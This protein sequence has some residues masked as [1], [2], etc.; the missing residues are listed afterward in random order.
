MSLRRPR[1][2]E[3]A[4]DNTPILQL[5]DDRRAPPTWRR[6]RVARSLTR[7]WKVVVGV[8]IL[9]LIE[10]VVHVRSFRIQRPAT[11]LDPPFH[12]GC[13]T[14]IL[15]TTER[16]NAAMVMLARNTDVDGAIDSIQSV[17][18]QFNQHFGYPWVFLNDKD[19]SP[20][21]VSRVGKVVKETGGGEAYFETI[22]TYMWGYPPWI[23]QGKARQ[24]MESM[25][26]RRIAYADIEITCALTYDPFVEM[27][28]NDKRYGYTVA[29]WEL[30]KT[31]PTLFQKLSD[32]K[33][34]RNMP[35]TS[36]WTAMMAPAWLP[37]PFRKI[38]RLLRNRDGNGD[39]WNMCHFWSNFE[40]ADMTFFRS[41][42]YREFFQFLDEDGGF[43]YERWGDAPVHSLAAGLLLRPDQVHHFS[44]L[45]YVH[46]PFQ[47]CT[48]APHEDAFKRGELVPDFDANDVRKAT[49]KEIGCNCFC[50]PNI[51]QVAPECFNRIKSTVM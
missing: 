40:I 36:L 30:G 33:N 31:V 28:R 39:M 12:V 9:C 8:L 34:K 23:D 19:W 2:S 32:W 7:H 10:S 13:Q 49:E 37:W 48:F 25:Q 14:P 24:E 16:A 22:P 50:D 27:E 35:S 46:K 15:N 1:T 29:L 17:Q 41:Q 6:R 21:F 42:E 43:Y 51:A 5:Q 18:N 4:S 44:D 3:M 26:N 38:L 11:N 45:G 20:E 47:Y